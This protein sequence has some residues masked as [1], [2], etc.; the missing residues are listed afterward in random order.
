ML[1]GELLPGF[2]GSSATASD[3]QDVHCFESKGNI[4]LSLRLESLKIVRLI[5]KITGYQ[6]RWERMSSK[7]SQGETAYQIA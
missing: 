4:I 7:L 1:P 3:L 2:T 6:M 5:P